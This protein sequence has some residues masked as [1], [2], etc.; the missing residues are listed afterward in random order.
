[1][2]AQ[3]RPMTAPTP[4]LKVQLTDKEK[5]YYSNLLQQA[6]PKGNNRVSGPEGAAFM[7]RSGLAKEVLRSIWL[8]A[9]KTSNEYLMR[10]EFYLAL[11]LIAYAQNGIQPTEESIRFNLEVALPRFDPVPL[12]LPPSDPV[13]QAPKQPT[14]EEIA[15]ALPD[16]D[17]LNIDALNQI[18]SLIP[19]VN[20]AEQE[21]HIMN[22]QMLGMRQQEQVQKNII[23]QAMQSPWYI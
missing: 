9:A 8:L 3:Q 1:M 4:A 12:A 13:R 18:H 16:L 21:K 15:A 11:R 2:A 20:K 10:D 17:H 23:Q 22:Q 7:R 5:G 14:A 6:D 19:S